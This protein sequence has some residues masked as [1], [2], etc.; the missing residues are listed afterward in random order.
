M[1]SVVLLYMP[2]IHRGYLDFLEKHKGEHEHCVLLGRDAIGML[3]E[4][5]QYILKKDSAVRAIPDDDV[6]YFVA[7]RFKTTRILTNVRSG[8]ERFDANHYLPLDAPGTP[9]L[10]IA[11]DEDVSVLAATHFFPLATHVFDDS[12]RLRYDRKGVAR[13]DPVPEGVSATSLEVHQHFIAKASEEAL[14]S[15]D[16][17]LQVGAAAVKG[18]ELLFV[19]FNKAMPDAITHLT[20]GDPRSIYSRGENTDDTL[21]LHAERDIVSQA[22]YHGV[23]LKG[24][25]VYVTHFPCVPCASGLARAGI[26]RLYFKEGYSRLESVSVLEKYNVEIIRVV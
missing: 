23:S 24:A 12:L 18:G 3:G 2:V 5:V 6:R 20:L 19:A 15:Y 25:E 21:V 9:E 13:V 22:A 17:W 4:S 14:K 16:W 7:G 10:V 8:N 26:A 1:K 11:P